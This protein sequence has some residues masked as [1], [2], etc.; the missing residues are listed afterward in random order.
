[1]LDAVELSNVESWRISEET[2]QEVR[3][4]DEKGEQMTYGE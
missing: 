2:K 3:D 4:L 1:M